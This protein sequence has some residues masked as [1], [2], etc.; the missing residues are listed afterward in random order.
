MMQMYY[1]LLFSI[2]FL[3]TAKINYFNN[4]SKIQKVILRWNDACFH[5]HHWITFTIILFA[6]IS[7]RY[8]TDLWFNFIIAIIFGIIAE[9]FLF[10]DVFDVKKTCGTIFKK[11][12]TGRT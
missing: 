10:K 1:I 3:L 4:K 5:I 2:S 9:S 8:L 6:F 12:F 11:T 7:G